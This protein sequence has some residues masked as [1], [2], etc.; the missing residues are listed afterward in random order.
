MNVAR[1]WESTLLGPLGSF[2][3]SF[4]PLVVISAC[5]PQQVT[6]DVYLYPRRSLRLLGS[7]KYP[8][9]ISGYEEEEA[10]MW[11]SHGQGT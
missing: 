4:L 8:L 1:K 11:S 2:N 3:I 5:R 6:D 10:A 7:N 9:T